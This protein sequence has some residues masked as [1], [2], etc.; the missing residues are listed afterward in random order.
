MVQ[1]DEVAF[2]PCA[3]TADASLNRLI[4]NDVLGI[5]TGVAGQ[6][7]SEVCSRNA[8]LELGRGAGL[9]ALEPARLGDQ[10]AAFATSADITQRRAAAQVLEDFGA[11]LGGLIATLRQPG[12]PAR[13]GHTP[14]RRAY[15]D[16]WLTVERVWLAGGLLRGAAGDVITRSA[17]AVLAFADQPCPLKIVPNPELAPLIGAACF[18]TTCDGTVVVGDLGH[19]SMKTAL[20]SIKDGAVVGLRQ[21][22]SVPSPTGRSPR[23]VTRATS[24]ALSAA[25]VDADSEIGPELEVIVSVASYVVHGRPIDDGRSIYGGLATAVEPMTT[26]LSAATGRSPSLRFVHDGTAAAAATG[27]EA[28]SAV[29]TVGSWLG[30]GFTPSPSSALKIPTDFAVA[31]RDPRATE[32]AS[33][34]TASPPDPPARFR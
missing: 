12:T 32:V 22:A 6:A 13:Q 17:R 24:Q 14:V 21:V 33:P 26:D 3:L 28:T 8:L 11:R 10:L 7:A 15:L 29:I 5:P 25:A 31:A 34:M 18:A 1:A 4:L 9:S 30:I 23:E 20:V 27:D 16:H 2:D 19:T